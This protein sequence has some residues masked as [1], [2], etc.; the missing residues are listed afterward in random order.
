[1]AAM[2]SRHTPA[3]P[4]PPQLATEGV[5]QRVAEG[6]VQAGHSGL[7]SRP[8]GVIGTRPEPTARPEL[9]ARPA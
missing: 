4:A 3:V 7:T 2:A 8:A 5:L 6:P 9:T 1:M